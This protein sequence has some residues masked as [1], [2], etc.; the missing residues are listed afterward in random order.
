MQA[1]NHT[2]NILAAL[3]IVS[4]LDGGMNTDLEVLYHNP[5][6]L[7]KGKNSPSPTERII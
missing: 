3:F 7:G 2:R 6:S 1:T 5:R 4:A